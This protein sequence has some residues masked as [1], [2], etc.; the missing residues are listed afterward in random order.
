MIARVT[1]DWIDIYGVGEAYIDI[2]TCEDY[3]TLPTE[4]ILSCLLIEN[5]WCGHPQF[6]GAAKPCEIRICKGGSSY[7]RF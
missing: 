2:L 7:P 3:P 5:H 4:D 6:S 1:M